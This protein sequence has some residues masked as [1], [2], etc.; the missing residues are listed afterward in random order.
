VEPTQLNQL[1]NSPNKNI[2]LLTSGVILETVSL[3]NFGIEN[4]EYCADPVCL[5]EVT[6]TSEICAVV[7]HECATGNMID[8]KF[9]PQGIT[10]DEEDKVWITLTCWELPESCEPVNDNKLDQFMLL[11]S[12]PCRAVQ[13]LRATI[14][15]AVTSQKVVSW[16]FAGKSVTL[17]NQ[18]SDE[19]Y[20]LLC[21]YEGKCREHKYE[22]TGCPQPTNSFRFIPD[23]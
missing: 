23:C 2:G 17:R 3:E 9:D 1:Y 7:L 4:N 21:Y 20:K 5:I 19:L 10:C 11:D 13:F 22:Q 12:D 18:R 6:S 15:E 14:L 8:Y 16:A